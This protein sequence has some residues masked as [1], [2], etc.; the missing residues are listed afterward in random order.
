MRRDEHVAGRGARHAEVAHGAIGCMVSLNDL[1]DRPP[2][3]LAD[4]EVLDLGGKRLRRSRHPARPARLGGAACSIEET[5]G[6]LL[7]G[8]LFTHVGDGAGADR[9]TTS[10]ARRWRPRRCSDA[11]CLTPHTGATLRTLADA[12]SRRRWP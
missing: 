3:A 7:C 11:T 10:S 1:A 6:T 2:R 5:T 12:G 4:G 9:A 8:D